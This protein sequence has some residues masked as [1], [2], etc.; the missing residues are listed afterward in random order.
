M[1]VAFHLGEEFH[2]YRYP[3][4]ET[5]RN[6]PPLCLLACYPSAPPAPVRIACQESRSD[7]K[8]GTVYQ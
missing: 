5:D 4:L 7:G 6:T 2:P 3:Y 1:P 8:V